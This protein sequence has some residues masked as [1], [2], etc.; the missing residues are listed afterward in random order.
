[1]EPIFL[2]TTTLFTIILITAEI[3]CLLDKG[4]ELFYHLIK[5]QIKNYNYNKKKGKLPTD[6]VHITKIKRIQIDPITIYNPETDSLETESKSF[7]Y[8]LYYFDQNKRMATMPVPKHTWTTLGNHSKH[9]NHIN[10][11]HLDIKIDT[12]SF[13]QLILNGIN[14]QLNTQNE[15][16]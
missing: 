12:N 16:Q 1:M 6:I 2:V 4:S 15:E 13:T 14:K 7:T 3:G 5:T 8:E 11:M 9:L 10:T